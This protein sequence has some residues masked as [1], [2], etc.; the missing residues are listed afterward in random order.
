MSVIIKRSLGQRVYKISEKLG[1]PKVTV[2]RVIKEYLDSLTESALKGENIVIDNLMSIQVIQDVETGEFFPRGRVSP[3]L[4][5]KLSK[6]EERE[7]E[8][9]G[10]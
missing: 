1:I 6:L 5:S 7:L 4:K 10:I 3:A 9:Q 8:T 2:E